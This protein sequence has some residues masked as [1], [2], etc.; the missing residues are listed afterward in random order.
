MNI[1]EFRNRWITLVLLA[2]RNLW[3]HRRRTFI[4]LSSVALGFSLAVAS[5]GLQ[6][7]SH[8]SMVRN[9]IRMGEGHITIQ[10]QDYRDSPA[11]YRFIGDGNKLAQSLSTLQFE[12]RIAP[13]IALQV[14][15]NTAS[16]SV[17][18]ILEGIDPEADPRVGQFRG[19]LVTGNWIESTDARGVVVGSN[20]ARKLKLETGRK[21]VIMIGKRG[22]DPE[23][24]LAL[25]RGIFNTG[26]DALDSYYIVSGMEFARHFLIAEGGNAELAP[27]TRVA[28]YLDDAD[29]LETWLPAIGKQVKE[30][31][32]AVLGWPE[33]MPELLQFIAIDDGF[34]YVMFFLILFVVVIGILNT[35]LMS[36]LERT[37]E[38]GL[39]RALG[40]S[41]DYL[42]ALV[43]CE[44]LLLSF[45]AVAVGW[46]LGGSFH[47]YLAFYGIDFS[48]LVPEG[49]EV[50]GTVMDPVVRSELSM[51]RVVQLTSIIFMAT[52]ASGIYPAIKAARVTPIEA[53]RT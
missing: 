41:R 14:L 52:L 49:T 45:L 30:P 46:I 17:G 50:M 24:R 47:L 21:L 5:I 8:N 23:A 6:D 16:N 2:W 18:A 36:V 28:L 7:G 19:K 26:I 32:I 3:R 43:F 12:G 20:M 51:T 44:S 48:A 9:G 4:T 34:S 25:V 27:V 11:N 13:R 40:L 38:F 33:M 1:F 37:R 29:Q 22:G 39:L 15:A 31:G 42:L 53:L 35:V 10:P